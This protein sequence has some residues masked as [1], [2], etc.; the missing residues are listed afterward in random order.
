MCNH[1]LGIHNLP[2]E[3]GI[4]IYSFDLEETLYHVR[5]YNEHKDDFMMF[6]YCPDCGNELTIPE[7]LS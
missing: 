4:F 7:I 1:F 3:Q 6:A 2:Y 5:K